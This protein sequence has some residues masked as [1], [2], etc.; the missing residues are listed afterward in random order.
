MDL[1]AQQKDLDERLETVKN[2]LVK[3]Q[4]AGALTEALYKQILEQLNSL[5]RERVILGAELSAANQAPGDSPL[6]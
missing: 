4:Q 6:Y 5:A 1:K 3:L 2:R